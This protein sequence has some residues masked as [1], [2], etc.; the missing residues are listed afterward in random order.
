MLSSISPLGERA[1]NQRWGITVSA[2][3]LAS[4]VAGATLGATLGA[5]GGLA[6]DGRSTTT[7][8]LLGVLAGFGLAVDLRVFGQRV[9]GLQRQVNEDWL[10]RYRGWVYGAGYGF[11]L[12]AAFATIVSSSIIYLVFAAALL[13]GNA[14]A[15]AVVGATFGMARALPIIATRNVGTWSELRRFMARI[16]RSA[17]RVQ[18]GAVAGQVAALAAAAGLVI[19]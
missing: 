15:G 1:R 3:S 5:L 11:Q 6:F 14:L 19:A 8:V 18:R 4:T 2:Y 10:A 13:S 17:P 12:G 9:P 7:L 16:E